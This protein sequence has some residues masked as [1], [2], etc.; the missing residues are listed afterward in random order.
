M[1]LKLSLFLLVLLLNGGAAARAQ[2]DVVLDAMSDELNRTMK[3]LH[4]PPYSLPY[5]ASFRIK[6][7]ED[8]TASSCLGS[9]AVVEHDRGRVFTP[10]V[11]IGDYSL[12]NSYPLTTRPIYS[13]SVQL[14]DDYAALRRKFWLQTDYTYKNAV[15]GFEWKKAYLSSNNVPDRLAD[16]THESATNSVAQVPNFSIDDG[17]WCQTLEDLSAL[18]KQYPQLQ[19]SKVSLIARQVT[20]WFVNSEGTK[21]KDCQSK[22]AVIFRASAQAS[23]GSITSDSDIVAVQSEKQMPSFD[24]LKDTAERLAKRVT[25]I[26]QAAKGT[27][28]CGPVLL[29]GQAAAEFF[30]Q[31]MAPN[32]G[33]AEDYIGSE[34]WRNPFKDAIGRRILPKYI[35]V[36][37]DPLSKDYK[38]TTL[39]G[40]Y[41]FD[42]DGV[43]AQKVTLVENGV[44]KNFCQSRIPSRH[45]DKSNGHSMGGHGVFNVLQ[46]SSSKADTP[47]EFKHQLTEL[48]KDAG[49]DY[50]LVVSRIADDFHLY[51]Y[52]STKGGPSVRPYATPSYSRQPSNPIEVYKLYISDWRREPVRGLEFRYVSL[53]AFRDIQAVL[54]DDKPYLV[55]PYDCVA[56]HI[57]TPSFLIGEL[58]LTPEKNEHSTPPI[59]PSPVSELKEQGVAPAT[60]P[61]DH[62]PER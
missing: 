45:S 11:R 47:D 48:A 44:L 18:F 7:V 19:K 3:D 49:L 26:S 54:P 57:V 43:P 24:V 5:F 31:L 46:V 62:R 8:A 55:E 2:G 1:K 61:G 50:V 6:D 13:M 9:K 36:V 52:P 51:E 56:R 42:D 27:E 21:V 40:G 25:M 60:E 37:D 15:T 4:I 20:N 28:Y 34:D 16:L 12:D 58:E 23:D 17:K 53:R 59:L 14:D 29:E 22:F 30:S 32:F 38:G 33:L 10:V 41:A 39:F 35:S